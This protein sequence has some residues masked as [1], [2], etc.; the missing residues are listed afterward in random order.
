M[1]S[2]IIPG[3]KS[4]QEATTQE[5][6]K[7]KYFHSFLTSFSPT[8]YPWKPLEYSKYCIKDTFGWDFARGGQTLSLGTWDTF[9]TSDTEVPFSF[10]IGSVTD[11]SF[12]LVPSEATR[13]LA[14]SQ[15]HL[16][17]GI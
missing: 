17:S 5:T 12:N 2:C 6:N 11:L 8:V 7:R 1:F 15:W 3:E 14:V 4:N 9:C 13:G 16:N 10:A